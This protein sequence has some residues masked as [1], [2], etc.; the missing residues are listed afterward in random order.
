MLLFSLK[1]Y[2]RNREAELQIEALIFSLGVT[3]VMREETKKLR[4]VG[5]VHRVD[6]EYCMTRIEGCVF[7]LGI[8]QLF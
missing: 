1:A 7:L 8:H 3:R 6:I 5:L 4:W 2:R